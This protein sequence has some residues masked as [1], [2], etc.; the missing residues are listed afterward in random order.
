M[1]A[2]AFAVHV[3]TACGG[4]LALL[5]LI[6]AVR[7]DWS[8]MFIALGLAVVVDAI[9]GPL[10]R[11][12]D[13]AER[14]PRWSGETLDLIIDF[15]TYVFVPAY[16]IATS[17]LLPDDLA[18]ATG[19]AITVSGALYFAKRDMKTDDNYF[20]GFPA[21]WN[22]VAFYLLLLL[23]SAW[24]ALAAVAAL[25]VLTFVPIRFVHPLRVVALRPLTIVLLAAWAIL[26]LIAVADGLK[27]AWWVV[28]SLSAIGLYFLAIGWLPQR[29]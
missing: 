21:V 14:L 20:R 10:A 17:G 8:A 28:G 23:P 5:A 27:P 26:A 24:I 25:V 18:V 3:L 4:M 13:I 29:R 15:A 2:L 19:A 7:A 16:A 22:V 9:D 11:R 1:R 6:A 12:L